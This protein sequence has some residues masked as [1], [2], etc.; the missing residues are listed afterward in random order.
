MLKL[1][2]AKSTEWMGNGFG[3]RTAEW[4]VKGNESIEVRKIGGNWIAFEGDKRIAKAWDKK[5]LLVKLEKFLL[6]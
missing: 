5:D 6:V 3:S 2:K 1:T 4:V